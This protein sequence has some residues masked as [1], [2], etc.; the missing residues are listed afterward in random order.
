[1]VEFILGSLFL[2]VVVA[3]L[4]LLTI[5]LHVATVAFAACVS[6][7]GSVQSSNSS[8]A[9]HKALSLLL[10]ANVFVGFAMPSTSDREGEEPVVDR[11]VDSKQSASTIY[12]QAVLAKLSNHLTEVHAWDV[13]VMEPDECVKNDPHLPSI[14]SRRCS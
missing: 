9:N 10:T 11:K 5:H 2:E 14:K 7:F 13:S 1:M 8:R 6:C 3:T 12:P 4:K